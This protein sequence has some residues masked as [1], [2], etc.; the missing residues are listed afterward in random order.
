MTDREKLIELFEKAKIQFSIDDGDVKLEAHDNNVEGYI[1]F[2]CRF[3]FDTEG[4]LKNA[5]IW[6]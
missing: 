2:V 4:N 3:S 5:G 1:G 6:E